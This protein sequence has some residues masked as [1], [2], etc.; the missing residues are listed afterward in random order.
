MLNYEFV[1][2]VQVMTLHKM[3]HMSPA[4]RLA[5]IIRPVHEFAWMAVN[6][7]RNFARQYHPPTLY[8]VHRSQYSILIRE[9]KITR[10]RKEPHFNQ[11]FLKVLEAI[12]CVYAY[13]YTI[14]KLQT[15]SM[16]SGSSVCRTDPS[17][18][19]YFF[20]AVQIVSTILVLPPLNLFLLYYDH[21]LR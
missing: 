20:Y 11:L 6:S 10:S 19:R 8:R 12:V 16:Y 7:M 21:I 2:P 15:R 3:K 4:Q 13:T 9:R 18:N 1:S 17:L 14:F 5:K